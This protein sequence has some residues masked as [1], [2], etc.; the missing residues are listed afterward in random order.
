MVSAIAGSMYCVFRLYQ[1]TGWGPAVRYAV[2]AMI[3]VW[4]PV[5]IAGKWGMLQQPWLLLKPQPLAV[6]FGGLA[7]GTWALWRA[8]RKSRQAPPF[9]AE[10]PPSETAPASHGIVPTALA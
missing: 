5:E 4:T 1:Q 7:L 6:F 9:V 2:A 3:V 8:Q 10:T